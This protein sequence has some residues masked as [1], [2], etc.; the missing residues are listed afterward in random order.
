M[1]SVALLMTK[2]TDLGDLS[3]GCVHS[4]TSGGLNIH[5]HS[6]PTRLRTRLTSLVVW[7]FI[8]M[9]SAIC[10]T[11][12]PLVEPFYHSSLER[13]TTG[14][15]FFTQSKLCRVNEI[16]TY[17]NAS[18]IYHPNPLEPYSSLVSDCSDLVCGVDT[19]YIMR[20]ASE[21]LYIICFLE[22]S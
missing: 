9:F 16:G 8:F 3:L 12:G 4:T 13:T 18:V 6:V 20:M 2:N 5:V 19:I 1:S 14:T 7:L 15:L 11:H 21:V 10:V 17:T 22:K